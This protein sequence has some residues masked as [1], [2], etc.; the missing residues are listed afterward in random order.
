MSDRKL[1][2]SVRISPDVLERLDKL[3]ERTGVGRGEIVE[4]CLLVGMQDEEE[5]VS[6]LESSIQGPI[7]SLIMHPKV[8]KV[9][10]AV[11]GMKGEIDE[12][13]QKVRKNVT[14]RRR[15]QRTVPKPS[16]G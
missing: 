9:L 7:Q 11:T 5:L 13:Q 10:L 2:L 15:A 16:H 12:T 8:L 4:R 6:W 3:V 1:I 14:E